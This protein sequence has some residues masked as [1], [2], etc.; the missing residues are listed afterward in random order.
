[1]AARAPPQRLLW[2]P[3]LRQLRQLFAWSCWL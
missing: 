1:M 2:P 3:P